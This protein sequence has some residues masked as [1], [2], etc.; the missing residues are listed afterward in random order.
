MTSRPASNWSR[1]AYDF[2]KSVS[3]NGVLEYKSDAFGG[4]LRGKLLI[5]RYSGGDD[6]II[7]TPGPDGRIVESVTGVTGLTGF[8]DPLVGEL[9]TY[10]EESEDFV[11][12]VQSEQPLSL[13]GEVD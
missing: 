5:T 9:C 7:L 12:D 8:V 10:S 3:P 4:L 11:C 2:G 1:E 6:V 13:V